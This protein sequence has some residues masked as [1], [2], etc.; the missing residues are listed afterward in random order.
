MTPVK[1]MDRAHAAVDALE[2]LV[3]GLGTAILAL[4]TLI[5]VAA[6]TVTSVVGVGLPFVHSAARAVRASAG[7]ERARLSRWGPEILDPEPLR[8]GLQVVRDPV[9]WRELAWVVLHST[10]GMV[11]GIIGVTLPIYAVQDTTDRKSVV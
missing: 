6:V 2:R 8:P 4:G 3:G 7:R 5:W 1:L 10:V 9:V 11:L